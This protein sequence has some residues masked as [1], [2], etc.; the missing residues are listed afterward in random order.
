MAHPK[1]V[2]AMWECHMPFP[3][4]R[5]FVLCTWDFGMM[6]ISALVR[7][8]GQQMFHATGALGGV[9]VIFTQVKL[10]LVCGAVWGCCPVHT[11]KKSCH[12]WSSLLGVVCFRH[13]SQMCRFIH[14]LKMDFFPDTE[15]S[16]VNSFLYVT[17]VCFCK[18]PLQQQFMNMLSHSIPNSDYERKGV[19]LPI[20]VEDKVKCDFNF[21]C[22]VKEGW[23]S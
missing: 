20:H 1:F 18:A 4:S 3:L 2:L 8:Q 12:L 5:L 19:G 11:W 21:H 10:V 7:N 16:L 9:L 15:S 6:K 17:C 22:T 23:I 13:T 14:S